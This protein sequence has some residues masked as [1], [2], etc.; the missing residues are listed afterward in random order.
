MRPEDEYM[1][2]VGTMILVTAI[3]IILVIKLIFSI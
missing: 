2:A 1:A 3:V